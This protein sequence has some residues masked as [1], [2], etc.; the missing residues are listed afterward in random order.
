MK[1]SS[2]HRTAIYKIAQRWYDALIRPRSTDEDSARREYI[3]NVILTGSIVMLIALDASVLY[4]SLRSG[5][6]YDGVPFMLF[7]I[8]PL[9]FILGH[10]LSRK[11]HFVAVSYLIIG[12]YFLSIDLAACYWSVRLPIFLISYVIVILMSGILIDTRF[13][14][15]MTGLIATFVIP[16]GYAQINHIIPVR[17]EEGANSSGSIVFAILFLLTM[18]LSWLSNRE[19]E[20]SLFRARRSE[21]ELKHERD[22][23]ETKVNERTQELRKTQFE[24]IEQIYRFAEFGRLA[25]GLFHDILNLLNAISLRTETGADKEANL[26]EAAETTKLIENFIQAIRKQL[27]HHESCELFSLV[28]SIN[29]A[30]QL[31]SYKATKENVR[32]MFH[33]DS[34]IRY[35]YFGDP[36]KFHQAIIN[37]LINA[38]ECYDGVPENDQRKRVAIIHLEKAEDRVTVR[39]ED[40]GCGVPANIQEKIFEPFFSTKSGVRGSG[41]GLAT[42]KK[43]VEEDLRGTITLSTRE[44]QQSVF[45]ISFPTRQPPSSNAQ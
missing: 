8:L 11:G 34:A 43:I 25:S 45:T 30:I 19:I 44:G 23:L 27:D 3:L 15:L 38:I 10:V 5:V 22:T 35:T 12:I 13:G 1:P 29:Q 21:R 40:H 26:V 42:V 9:T 39:I 28:D 33:Y 2:P 31:V 7:S 4:Y 24:K 32:I 16:V 6:D 20:K 14:L 41:I 17:P 37:T 36:F 18:M